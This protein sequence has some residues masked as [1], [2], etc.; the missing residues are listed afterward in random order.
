MGKL[1]QFCSLSLAL[2][3]N[4]IAQIPNGLAPMIY[5][6][7]YKKTRIKNHLMFFFCASNHCYHQTFSGV[8]VSPY[9]P[10]STI[11]MNLVYWWGWLR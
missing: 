3:D 7:F 1:E 4:D 5:F 9:L 10:S 8:F 6:H 2:L 11:W